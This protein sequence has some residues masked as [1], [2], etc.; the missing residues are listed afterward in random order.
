MMRVTFTQINDMVQRNISNNYGKLANMQEQ[1][2]TGRRL[3]RP[4]DDPID[5]KNNI[6]YKAEM[7][8]NDQY[9]RNIQDGQAWLSMTE[10]AMTDMNDIMQKLRELAIQGSNDTLVGT[11]RQYIG[12]EVNQLVNQLVSLSNSKYKGDFIFG[13]TNGDKQ[14]YR[15]D[16][17]TNYSFAPTGLG[18]NTFQVGVDNPMTVYNDHKIYQYKR[19]DPGTLSLSYV[20]GGV[21]AAAVEG[22]DYTVN[23]A[24]GTIRAVAGSAFETALNAGPTTVNLIFNNYYKVN[25][26]NSGSI[27]REI[28]EGVKPRVNMSADD[29]FEDPASN[30]DMIGVGLTLL[31]GLK[32]NDSS[33]INDTI[34]SI[35]TIF[36]K[37]KAAES[38]NGAKVNRF[39]LTLT[40]TEN[41]QIEVTR[42][43]SDLEDLDFAQAMMEFNL[44]QNVYT[45]SLQAGAKV[46]LPTLGD[47]I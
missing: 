47:Y 39:D 2:S 9:K 45:A 30:L 29:V 1:L 19:I 8:Q 17:K 27:Y 44:S 35:D 3:N 40:R 15:Y 32:K 46:I 26:E 36:N 20:T 34:S 43:Q 5:M 4:S 38:T 41:R 28:E 12:Q 18:A 14:I 7:A 16:Q 24:N 13:G 25:Q 22:T 21:T 33:K 23:Y 11:E 10:V 42:L 31:D 37:M 6:G